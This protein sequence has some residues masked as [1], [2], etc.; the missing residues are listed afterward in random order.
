MQ[1]QFIGLHVP[2]E[3]KEKIKEEA[4]KAKRTLSAEVYQLIEE[5]LEAREEQ[6]A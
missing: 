5:A 1:K 6:K 2:S 3:L 4:K